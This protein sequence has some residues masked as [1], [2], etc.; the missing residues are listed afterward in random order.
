MNTNVRHRLKI[1][2]RAQ[3]VI[4]KKRNSLFAND[5]FLIKDCRRIT[6]KV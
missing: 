4:E 3:T 6:S 1:L 2:Q 5:S